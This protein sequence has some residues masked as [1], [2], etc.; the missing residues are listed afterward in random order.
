M[1]APP[2][3]PPMARDPPRSL[4]ETPRRHLANVHRA[5]VLPAPALRSLVPPFIR[6]LMTKL[7]LR[8]NRLPADR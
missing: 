3:R 5:Q 6:P 1:Y 8:L 7:Y 4:E 2:T